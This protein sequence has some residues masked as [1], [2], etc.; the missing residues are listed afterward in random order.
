M[1]RH[2]IGILAILLL[3]GAVWFKI[4]PPEPHQSFLH[5]LDSACS[6]AGALAAVIW[7][8]YSEIHRMPAW[9]WLSLPVLAVVLVKWPK[10]ILYAL[11]VIVI[12]A[13][14]RPRTGKRR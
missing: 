10:C 14:L 12:I 11:P 9:C 8:A 6:R 7:L 1:R 2:L 5:G 4:F 3:L 13:V